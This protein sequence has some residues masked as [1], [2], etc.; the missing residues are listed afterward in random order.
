MNLAV[1]DIGSNSIRLSV[2]KKDGDTITNIFNRKNMA[3]LANYIKKDKL[4]EEGIQ[5]L[6]EALKEC[7]CLLEHF[8]I[9]SN[10]YVFATASLRNISNIFIIKERVK[11]ETGYDIEILS[12][13]DEAQLSFKG[14]LSS[15]DMHTDDEGVFIDI[16]GGSTE[17]V[18]F[19]GED[20]SFS[21]SLDI[22][23]LKIYRNYVDSLFPNK[24]EY[25]IIR[26]K[27]KQFMD[28]EN[29]PKENKD[30]IYAVGGSP[31]ALL[32]YYNKHYK[33]SRDNVLMDSS[34][35]KELIGEIQKKK[36]SKFMNDIL[37]LKPER[38]HTIIPGLIILEAIIDRFKTKG[39][40]VSSTGLREGYLNSKIDWEI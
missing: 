33:K 40:F 24:H 20:F 14:A 36:Y 31:R 8:G 6:V 12:G 29:V 32:A 18:I 38:I 11:L 21:S 17:I 19:N 30:M 4:S 1:I 10:L 3:G 5:V 2:Y 16:G 28:R 34:D 13:K 23:A 15:K 37:K 7:Q 9:F 22:G 39:V 26:K 27:V 25:R 35:L